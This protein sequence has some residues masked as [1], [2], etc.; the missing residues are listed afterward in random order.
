MRA[1]MMPL[2]YVT[3]LG[4]RHGGYPDLMLEMCFAGSRERS[5][6]AERRDPRLWFVVA[7]TGCGL[8]F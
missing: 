3:S 4:S 1:E 7:W 8:V 2:D 6:L 5:V